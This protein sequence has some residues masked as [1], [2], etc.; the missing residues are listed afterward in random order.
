M[1]AART[2]LSERVPASPAAKRIAKEKGIDLASLKGS[3]PE[4]AVLA[5][6]VVRAAGTEAAAPGGPPKIKETVQLTPMRRIVGERMTKSKQTA[7]HFYLSMDADM[8][9]VTRRRNALKEKGE[10]PCS[11]DQ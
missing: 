3:G 5:E 6:D 4:G 11:I 2:A 7:P 9:E 10:S 1:R 8:T